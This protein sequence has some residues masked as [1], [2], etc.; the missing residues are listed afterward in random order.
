MIPLAETSSFISS[1]KRRKRA[2]ESG[3]DATR[4]AARFA[5]AYTEDMHRLGN[6]DPD[7][8]P[9]VSEHMDSILALVSRLLERDHAYRADGDVYFHVPSFA[10]Y[11]K[12]SQA[13]GLG[14]GGERAHTRA[15]GEQEEAPGGLRLVEGGEGG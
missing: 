1:S 10:G 7:V 4:L 13:R 9:R 12:L 5:D 8:E 2:A 3:E 14:H 15:R 11:G 6:L